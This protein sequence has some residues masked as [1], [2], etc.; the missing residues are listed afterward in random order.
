MRQIC[1]TKTL[2]VVGMIVMTGCAST[3]PG[4]YGAMPSSQE[5]AARAVLD[6]RNLAATLRAMAHQRE[7]EAEMLS[8]QPNP[9]QERL[10]HWR[11]MAETLRKQADEAE[12]HSRDMQR[13]VPHGMMQ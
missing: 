12:R 5:E 10:A 9:D 11:E 7:L 3:Q 2:L 1:V 13:N 6:Y 4:E 8:L